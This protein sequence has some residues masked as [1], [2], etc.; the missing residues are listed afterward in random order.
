[1]TT[2]RRLIVQSA[3]LVLVSVLAQE[4]T[5]GPPTEQLS[6]RIDRVVKVLE[7]P[8]LRKEGKTAERRQEIRRIAGEIFDFTEVA[9]RS[10]GRHWAGRTPA[11]QEEFVG[12][13]T[14]L[15]ERTYVS[16]M[17]LYAGEKISMVGESVDGDQATVR[18]KILSRQGIQT[19]IDYRMYRRGDRW[20]VYDVTI[21]GISLVAN[22]RAQFARIMQSG[23]YPDLVR[24]LK[25][26]L[27]EPVEEP[28]RTSQK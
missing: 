5:A 16:K 9:K 6:A 17:E 12:L 25:E 19:P 21:E 27:S 13:F 1:M 26:K 18:T 4:A 3:V 28:R 2:R 11:E 24:K 8:A 7:D 15:L 14:D 20:T 10:L 22:Y 23:S